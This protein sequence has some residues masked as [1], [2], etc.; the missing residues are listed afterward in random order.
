[1]FKKLNTKD[2]FHCYK[3]NYEDPA[4][5]KDETSIPKIPSK[6]LPIKEMHEY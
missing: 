6:G 5:A 4:M 2:H 1:M 3:K